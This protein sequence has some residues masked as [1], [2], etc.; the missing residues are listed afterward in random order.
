MIFLILT[1]VLITSL[2][3][4]FKWFEIFEINTFQAIVVNYCVCVITGFFFLDKN[5]LQQID[6]DWQWIKLG[7]LSGM[8]FIGTL[9]MMALAAQKVS[10]SLS[11]LASKMSLVIPVLISLFFFKG[12]EYSLINY[13]GLGISFIA[14]GLSSINTENKE[15]TQTNQFYYLL[16]P[17]IFVCSGS[18]DALVNYANTFLKTENET[19][20]FPITIFGS[21]CL[22]GLIIIL[23]KLL[24]KQEKI[25]FKNMLGGIALG[26]PNY[27]SIYYLLKSLSYYNNNGAKVYPIINIGIILLST[28]CA[29]LFF[30]E[31]L[32]NIKIIG[33]ILSISS[34]LLIFH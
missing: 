12:N 5:T 27:F 9:Y 11:S 6:F 21:A 25:E 28:F 30:K 8:G 2:F 3:L 32:T 4:S 13:I 16:I 26:V 7:C 34:I 22:V 33:I 29:I 18:L 10:V 20:F 24:F 14:I 23:Y 1:I 17:L 19:R 15:S 31:K